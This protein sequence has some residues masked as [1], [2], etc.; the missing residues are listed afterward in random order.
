MAR[1]APASARV[2]PSGVLFGATGDLARRQVLP[3]LAHLATGDSYPAAG[4]SEFRSQD[5]TPRSF[6]TLQRAAVAEFGGRKFSDA[7]WNGFAAASTT[8]RWPRGLQPMRAAVERAEQSIGSTNAA[9][10]LSQRAA[11]C[12]AFCGAL[13]GRSRMVEGSRIIMETLLEPT[14]PARSS[15]TAACTRCQRGA[16][17]PHR[18]FPGKE[19]AQ[20]IR[21]FR[22][23]MGCSN[24][25]GT[26]T[27]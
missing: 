6:A 1:P 10:C 17:F 25:S 21:A 19:P 12:G 16:D 26:A 20:N 5:L 13:P 24:P 11:E 23:P 2:S 22:L 15:S 14:W 7:D 18:S 9:A 27:S 4:S 8:C 3:G